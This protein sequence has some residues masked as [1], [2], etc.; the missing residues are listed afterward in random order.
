MTTNTEA[1][2]VATLARAPQNPWHSQTRWTN[3]WGQVTLNPSDAGSYT[4][5]NSRV[6]IATDPSGLDV[7]N[8]AWVRDRVR[9]N[10]CKPQPGD[11]FD[12]VMSGARDAGFGLANGAYMTAEGYAVGAATV[13]GG[14]VGGQLVLNELEYV[15]HWLEDW[16]GANTDSRLYLGGTGV[17][18]VGTGLVGGEGG[19]IGAGARGL[20]TLG[21]KVI[22]ALGR[23]FKR[24]AADSVA[25]SWAD[26]AGLDRTVQVGGNS[27][28][29]LGDVSRSGSTVTIDNIALYGADGDL[30]NQVGAQALRDAGGSLLREASGS[31]V[32]QIVFRGVRGVK[33]SGKPG[34][35]VN[36]VATL[37]DDGSVLWTL[38]R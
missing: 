38:G 29:I 25:T 31:G 4:Y 34:H 30:V 24:E 19:A 22:S 26:A 1:G 6:G 33:S 20:K 7:D 14:P 17:G 21:S 12:K 10:P 8:A 37:G 3:P 15:R 11:P 28:S 23:L 9:A 18:V 16:G 36:W 35:V 5:A 2:P 32:T 27:V 13:A